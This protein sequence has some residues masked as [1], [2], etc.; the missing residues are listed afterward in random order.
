M[1]KSIKL[2]KELEA[3]LTR[4]LD[5]AC[6]GVIISTTRLTPKPI[7]IALPAERKRRNIIRE[8]KDNVER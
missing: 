7:N 8:R 6:A 5:A 3:E 2:D 1:R 4:E